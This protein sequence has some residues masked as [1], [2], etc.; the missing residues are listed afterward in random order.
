[1]KKK[2]GDVGGSGGDASPPASASR[3]RA[4]KLAPIAVPWLL[5]AAAIVYSSP[6]LF[7][8]G[9]ILAW[10]SSSP[11]HNSASGGDES[12]IQRSDAT[13]ISNA[14][15]SL[16]DRAD[17]C[18]LSD[19]EL[20]FLGGG[21]DGHAFLARV[22]CSLPSDRTNSIVI[23]LPIRRH[24]E[25]VHKYLS[26]DDKER[27]VN[28][29]A[30][31][32]YQHML[33]NS[34]ERDVLKNFAI[35]LGTVRVSKKSLRID[36]NE[37]E[38]NVRR[39]GM[40]INGTRENWITGRVMPHVEGGSLAQILHNAKRRGIERSLRRRIARDLVRMYRHMYERGVVHCDISPTHF[41]WD[42]ASNTTVLIDFDRHLLMDRDVRRDDVALRRNITHNQQWQM[43]GM[44]CNLC[45]GKEDACDVP[46]NVGR[47][48]YLS[49][50][51]RTEFLKE[52]LKECRFPDVIS[53]PAPTNVN[54][55][56]ESVAQ[57]YDALSLWSG[58]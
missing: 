22:E 52:A 26:I 19:P 4:A 38:R 23:K 44:I 21:M 33:T 12:P 42:D 24:G 39:F 1:M 16:Y 31:L 54:E 13:P 49:L 9:D 37:E 17:R 5:A 15:F 53:F 51:G 56:D 47:K 6:A 20:R 14:T 34:T 18:T 58:A 32:L 57:L 46:N 30:K 50:P 10:T 27:G 41:K 28:S 36:K 2:C 8:G 3:R 55:T 11:M 25:Q 48:R 35:P 40:A 29:N 43:L 7:R 45:L